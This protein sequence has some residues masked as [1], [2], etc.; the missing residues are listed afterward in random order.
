MVENDRWK[1]K[2]DLERLADPVERTLA[3][4][5]KLCYIEG[6]KKKK[7]WFIFFVFFFLSWI[8]LTLHSRFTV[9]QG[10]REAIFNSLYINRAITAESSTLHVASGQNRIENPWFTSV[11]GKTLSYAVYFLQ[12]H[13]F[14][15]TIGFFKVSVS[16]HTKLPILTLFCACSMLSKIEYVVAALR[17]KDS[18]H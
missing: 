4:R 5:L 15:I 10:N 18:P 1:R 13:S 3:E 17:S 9:Q 12:F 14:L 11:N 7:G 6:K 2:E 8:S 16:M